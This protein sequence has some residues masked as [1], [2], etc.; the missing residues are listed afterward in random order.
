M[1]HVCLYAGLRPGADPAQKEFDV[2]AR[3]GLTVA[4]LVGEARLGGGTVGIVVV[5]GRA[6]DLG[7]RLE[8][9]DRV[10]LFPAVSGG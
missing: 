6:A 10:A 2:E 8:E 3:P 7:S 9:G 1:I 5:N 4:E